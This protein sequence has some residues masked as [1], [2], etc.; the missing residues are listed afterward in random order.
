MINSPPVFVWNTGGINLSNSVD[1]RS[2]VKNYLRS[3]NEIWGQ[4]AVV[5]F[6][7]DAYGAGSVGF[8]EATSQL[9]QR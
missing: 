8:P 1:P 5:V 7:G 6:G 4:T 9:W 2:E 3:I